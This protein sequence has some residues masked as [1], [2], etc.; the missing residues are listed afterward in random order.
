MAIG[1]RMKIL[2]AAS[3]LSLCVLPAPPAG[4][5]DVS[6]QPGSG[7]PEV[8]PRPDFHLRNNAAFGVLKAS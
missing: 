3:S 8:R 6:P 4:P 1:A 2:L 7:T 5:K